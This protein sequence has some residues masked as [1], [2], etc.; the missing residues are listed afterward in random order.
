MTDKNKKVKQ[1]EIS[2]VVENEK[3]K[4][5]NIDDLAK[6]MSVT[7]SKFP[8]IVMV[9]GEKVEMKPINDIVVIPWFARTGNGYNGNLINNGFTIPFIGDGSP[10]KSD[11][12]YKG[13]SGDINIYATTGST[14]DLKMGYNYYLGN[15]KPSKNIFVNA[16]KLVV[17]QLD[18]NGTLALVNTLMDLQSLFIA[19]EVIL[20]NSTILNASKTAVIKA[21]TITNSRISPSDRIWIEK[22]EVSN[23]SLGSVSSLDIE[24]STVASRSAQWWGVGDH[25]KINIKD[26]RYMF[27]D[28]LPYCYPTVEVGIEIEIYHRTHYGMFTGLKPVPF[29]RLKG[30]RILLSGGEVVTLKELEDMIPPSGPFGTGNRFAGDLPKNELRDKLAVTFAGYDCQMDSRLVYETYG[31]SFGSFLRAIISRLK[32]FKAVAAVKMA[33]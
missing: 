2:G 7:I 27:W 17:K 29:V 19:N 14:V 12:W 24:T 21:S 13:V 16:S 25:G 5:F 4:P 28:E 15:D 23:L 3:L 8:P 11:V 18:L 10:P 22:S 33:N 1:S 32:V 6:D 30:E 9:D 20:D 26:Q 31:E